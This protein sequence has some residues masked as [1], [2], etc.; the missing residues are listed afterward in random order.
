VQPLLVLAGIAALAAFGLWLYQQSQ[1]QSVREPRPRRIPTGMSQPAVRRI[2]DAHRAEPSL[3][4]PARQTL[5]A[6]KEG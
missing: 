5:L 6:A 4:E 2:T 3:A 1:Q